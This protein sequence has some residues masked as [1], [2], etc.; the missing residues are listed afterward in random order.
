MKTMKKK[1]DAPLPD[2]YEVYA[3]TPNGRE[4]RTAVVA[5][6]RRYWVQPQHDNYWLCV[7]SPRAALLAFEHPE[8]YR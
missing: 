8:R 5:G 6:R 3:E 2:D 4:I 1:N 7:S